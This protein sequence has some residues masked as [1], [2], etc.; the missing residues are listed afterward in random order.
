MK[1]IRDLR[2]DST[3]NVGLSNNTVILLHTKS[4]AGPRQI[5]FVRTNTPATGHGSSKTLMAP[6]VRCRDIS[7]AL[8]KSCK[9]IR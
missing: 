4:P 1:G 3:G 6:S 5:G 9:G 2:A 8:S 7:T